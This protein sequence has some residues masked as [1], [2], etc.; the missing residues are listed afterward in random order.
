[1]RR[2]IDKRE[3]RQIW[4][5]VF[6][7]SE[8]FVELYFRRRYS[9]ANTFVSKADGRI[10]AQ[11]QCLTYRMTDS[12]C[13]PTLRIG[14]VSGL[15][16][17]PAYRGQGHAT[18]VMQQMHQWLRDNGYDYCLL[19]PADDHAA[20]WYSHHLDYRPSSI[21]RKLRL[22]PTQMAGFTK[23]P[24]LTP[25]IIDTLQRDLAS[26]PY[27]V[28]H[29]AT[30]LAD[31]MAVCQMTGGGLYAAAQGLLMAER[32]TESDGKE[33]YLVLDTF[34]LPSSS[35]FVSPCLYLPL[36]NNAPL[37]PTVRMTLMLE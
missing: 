34:L 10:V 16:T 29:T 2:P 20:K 26:T 12:Q 36:G 8:E 35:P 9:A 13:S 23:L 27:T 18:A 4:Q 19:I 30:D 31:Q 11:A 3:C 25:E 21:E 32:I 24:A 15:A 6:R 37:P 17:L 33:S 28:Q 14:Y 7:D 5:T 22:S 1:M